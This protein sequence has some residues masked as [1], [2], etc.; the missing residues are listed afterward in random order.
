MIKTKSNVL[1]TGGAGYIGSHTCKALARAGY[2]PVVY[3][4]LCRGNSWAVKWGPL[5]VGD[6]LDGERLREVI[7]KHKPVGVIHFAALAYVGESMIDPLLYYRNNVGG[8]VSLLQAMQA[9][10]LERFVFSSTCATYGSPESNPIHEMM[11]QNPINPYGMSKLMVEQ[12]MQ[13]Y[14][15]AGS[16]SAIALRYFN[17]AG[18]DADCE[19]GESH[20]PETHLIPLT[21]GAAKGIYSPLTVFGWEHP[22]PDG[23]CIR[24]YIHVTDLADAHLKAL[25][26]TERN[27]GF[28]AF[29]LGTG[30]GVS[31]KELIEMAQEVTGHKVPH[32]YGPPR[33]GDP[34]ALVADPSRAREVLGWSTQQSDLRNILATAW[35]WME[36]QT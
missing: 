15:H 2:T 34:S 33:A 8:T 6:L 29:N 25:A 5:E 3:D 35:A 12:I 31:I 36:K 32:S 4:S 7:R 27:A 26:Y 22:T 17:A 21:L 20:D 10:G 1:V 18:A 30:T 9:E 11:P 16:L 28:D 13:D 19:I 14:S 24:D 23:T